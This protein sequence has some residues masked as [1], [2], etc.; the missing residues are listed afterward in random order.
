MITDVDPSI[1]TDL[2]VN[3]IAT[4]HGVSPGQILLRW[5]VQRGTI[6]IPKS[7]TPSRIAQN[8][9]VYG[10]ALSAEEVAALATL[11]VHHRFVKGQP[12]TVGAQPWEALWDEDF[13]YNASDDASGGAASR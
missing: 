1:L 4:A 3:R 8:L 9:D 13:D 5:A 6:A 11:D 10:F 12:S 2:T 7:V